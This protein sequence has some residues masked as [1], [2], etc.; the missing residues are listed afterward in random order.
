MGWGLAGGA[1]RVA[2][3]VQ[4][5]VARQGGDWRASACTRCALGDKG[6]RTGTAARPAPPRPVLASLWQ[7]KKYLLEP[8]LNC[9][10]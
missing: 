2:E 10:G 3:A 9:A 7:G 6:A 1:G 5:R 4:C 8:R